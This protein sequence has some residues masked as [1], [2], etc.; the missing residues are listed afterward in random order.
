MFQYLKDLLIGSANSLNRH[1][2]VLEVS[3]KEAWDKIV[4]HVSIKNIKNM[5]E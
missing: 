3:Y 2:P 4:K 1:L 5:F